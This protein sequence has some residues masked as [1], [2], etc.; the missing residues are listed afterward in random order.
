VLK[1]FLSLA[2]GVF[3]GRAWYST[4]YGSLNLSLL[5]NILVDVLLILVGCAIA[6]DEHVLSF[7]DHGRAAVA[8]VVSAVF[9]SLTAAYF[10][11]LIL[12]LPL[13]V[14]LSAAAGFG[15]YSFTGPFLSKAIGLEAGMLGL[16]SN[17]MRELAT[18]LASPV[19]GK[20]LGP[21]S[22][23][24]GGGATSC[25]TTLPFIMK[26]GGGEYAVPAIASG[27]T[28]TAAAAILVPLFSQI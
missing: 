22:I 8:S 24:S 7:K 26:Y 13:N 17:L 5:E 10:S 4:C 15:W 14:C 20:K 16:L 25:D 23:I 28:L 27:L 9:G 18:M 3:V 6:L 11:S 19:L 12:N 2:A 21:V 1:F